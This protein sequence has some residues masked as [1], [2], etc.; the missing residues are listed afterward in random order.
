MLDVL[1][2]DMVQSDILKTLSH[3][4]RT[5]IM[6]PGLFDLTLPFNI[7]YIDILF[8]PLKI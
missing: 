8:S 1:Y 3:I 2:N 6:M 7:R 5:G 4:C